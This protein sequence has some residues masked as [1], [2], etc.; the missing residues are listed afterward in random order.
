MESRLMWAREGMRHARARRTFDLACVIPD[1][2]GVAAGRGSPSRACKGCSSKLHT[3]NRPLQLDVFDG[4]GS[5]ATR[6]LVV[7]R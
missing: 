1:S 4:G 6:R 3:V 2:G 7:E 5:S